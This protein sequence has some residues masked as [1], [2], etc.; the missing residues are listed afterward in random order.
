MEEEMHVACSKSLGRKERTKREGIPL[1][2]NKLNDDLRKGF[3][4]MPL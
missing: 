2:L 1:K 3:I 4:S